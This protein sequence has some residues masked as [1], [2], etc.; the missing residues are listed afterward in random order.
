[1]SSVPQLHDYLIDT[2]QRLPDKTALAALNLQP[3]AFESFIGISPRN[4]AS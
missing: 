4:G 1:M 2:T 3:A